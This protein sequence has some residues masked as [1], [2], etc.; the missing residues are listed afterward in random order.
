MIK[1]IHTAQDYQ[2]ALERAEKL[3]GSE[4]NTS[5]G[6]ELDVLLVLIEA[7]ENKH[8]PMP[9]SDPVNAILFFMDQ[10]NLNRKDL[11]QFLGAKSRVSDILN[12]KRH[13]TMP[14][15]VKLHKGLHIPYECLIEERQYL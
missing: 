1:P 11:E 15:I 7:Y 4:P 10:M 3:W 8:Y 14:Q 13:L 6:D 12:R 5:K 2:I 9:P